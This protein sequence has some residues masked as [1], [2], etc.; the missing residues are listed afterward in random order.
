MTKLH[1]DLDTGLQK[2]FKIEQ[3]HLRHYDVDCT[4]DN[5]SILKRSVVSASGSSDYF[6]L[7]DEALPICAIE[8]QNHQRSCVKTAYVKRDYRGKGIFS[9]MIDYLLSKREVLEIDT[10]Q[11]V[12]MTKALSK[13][14]LK[15]NVV[16]ESFDSKVHKQW[17]RSHEFYSTHGYTGWHVVVER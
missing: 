8:L 10:E 15:H 4:I 14:A 3:K 7:L 6:M 2:F 12:K 9:F 11:S 17:S 5:M 16:W 13:I 1:Q